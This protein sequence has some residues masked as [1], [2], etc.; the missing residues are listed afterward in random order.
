MVCILFLT[1][2]SFNRTH[3]LILFIRLL[4]RWCRRCRRWI[5]LRL[6]MLVCRGIQYEAVYYFLYLSFTDMYLPIDNVYLSF[7]CVE[8]LFNCV[9]LS[10]NYVYLPFNC[11]DLPFNCVYLSFNYVLIIQ[12]AMPFYSSFNYGLLLI[13][14]SIS[15]QYWLTVIPEP[16][17]ALLN[18]W[19]LLN[20]QG[21]QTNQDGEGDWGRADKCVNVAFQQ[22]NG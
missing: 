10:F 17:I 13:N 4:N 7:N 18:R 14:Y 22:Q 12:C 9:H 3:L 11:V 5:S 15:I 16:A 6:H 20:A 8:L 21:Q 19:Q 2:V 1:K